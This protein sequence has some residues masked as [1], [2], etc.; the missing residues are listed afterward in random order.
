MVSRAW[1]D[2]DIDVYELGRGTFF[3]FKATYLLHCTVTVTVG[4]EAQL[5]GGHKR[6]NDERTV[7]ACGW[8]CSVD[9][10]GGECEFSLR[11]RWGSIDLT[12]TTTTTA[13]AD[14]IEIAR[15]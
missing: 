8:L 14:G 2:I 10:S 7:C 11:H 15:R 1:S 9:K 5:S 12:T 13:V 3:W 4:C 6:R